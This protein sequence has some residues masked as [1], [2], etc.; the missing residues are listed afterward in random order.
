MIRSNTSCTAVLFEVMQTHSPSE[1]G[2][3]HMLEAMQPEIQSGK[4]LSNLEPF[5]CSPC[6]TCS[7]SLVLKWAPRHEAH[8]ARKRAVSMPFLLSPGFRGSH[9]TVTL[10]LEI[11]CCAKSNTENLRY[12]CDP[13][14]VNGAKPLIRKWAFLNG[15]MLVCI[16]RRS[17]FNGPLNRRQ[18]VMQDIQSATMLLISLILGTSLSRVRVQMSLKAALSNKKTWCDCSSKSC[19]ARAA[20]YGSMT[21]SAMFGAGHTAKFCMM[22]LLP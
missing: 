6:V 11:I 22:H 10:S 15:T 3:S 14:A 4:C 5:R 17:E 16:L 12:F 8:E 2:T 18:D 21:T 20:L 19:I 7:T 9:F 13:G 1:C